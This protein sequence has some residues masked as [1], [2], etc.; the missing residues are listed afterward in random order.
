MGQWPMRIDVV[1]QCCSLK[2]I[3]CTSL[4]SASFFIVVG[5]LANGR[6]AYEK[7][8]ELTCSFSILQD[9]GILKIFSFKI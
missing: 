8:N 9:F 6:K 1:Y 3:F 7:K 4:T 2:E 5:F